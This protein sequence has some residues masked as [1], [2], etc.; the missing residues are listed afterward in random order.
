MTVFLKAFDVVDE[1][2][3]YVASEP[4]LAEF[5][6]ELREVREQAWRLAQ[7]GKT[8]RALPRTL[9]RSMPDRS[10]A[11]RIVEIMAKL[12]PLSP[13]EMDHESV[14]LFAQLVGNLVVAITHAIF[15]RYPELMR[16]PN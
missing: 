9:T 7:G 1:L 5:L 16:S 15:V 10:V 14:G 3:R 6:P 4:R 12:P 13:Q 2:H 8:I 11:Q